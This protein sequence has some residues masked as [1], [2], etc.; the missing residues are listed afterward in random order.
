MLTTCLSL[1]AIAASTLADPTD[2][3]TRTAT[4]ADAALER[5]VTILEATLRQPPP[6]EALS[7]V[8]FRGG[9]PLPI[10]PM[11][12]PGAIALDRVTRQ[13]LRREGRIL[14]Y[15]PTPHPHF[16]AA[17]EGGRSR[18][19]ALGVEIPVSEVGLAMLDIPVPPSQT[20]ALMA[21]SGPLVGKVP[22]VAPAA[23]VQIRNW[24]GHGAAQAQFGGVKLAYAPLGQTGL[25]VLAS[26]FVVAA[27][28]ASATLTPSASLLAS[29]PAAIAF[30]S[31]PSASPSGLPLRFRAGWGWA[32]GLGVLAALVG[33]LAWLRSRWQRQL[34]APL[35]RAQRS[36]SSEVARLVSSVASGLPALRSE[37]AS[38]ATLLSELETSEEPRVGDLAVDLAEQAANLHERLQ[39]ASDRPV[40]LTEEAWRQAADTLQELA[41]KVALDVAHVERSDKRE[42]LARTAARMHDLAREMLHHAEAR[43]DEAAG[44]APTLGYV[45]ELAGAL[46]TRCE[47]L[48]ATL[49]GSD[50][51][52]QA[53][54]Q[55]TQLAEARRGLERSRDTI[56][57]LS[58][59]V[60]ALDQ[61]LQ[62]LAQDEG[63]AS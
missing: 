46:R 16:V 63:S 40:S 60:I 47:R 37:L 10:R 42:E 23:Q 7:L 24:I 15:Y 50:A 56:E 3:A 2:L 18:R 32:A 52:L 38:V 8:I 36:P 26:Q 11:Y 12:G 4:N 25:G 30:I 1:A 9:S 33:L 13:H 43:P 53:R 62:L 51:Q 55:A 57:L 48:E 17:V 41:M 45:T 34:G 44:W 61:V 20:L 19:R 39:Q 54:A 5:A 29:A 35:P 59:R 21:Q 58:E 6:R 22:P 27:P 49:M 31:V 14:H 28:L